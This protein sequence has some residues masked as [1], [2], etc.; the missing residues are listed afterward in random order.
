METRKED[1]AEEVDMVITEDEVEGGLT[2]DVMSLP[3]E[4]HQG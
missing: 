3:G 4:M 1:E 2:Q